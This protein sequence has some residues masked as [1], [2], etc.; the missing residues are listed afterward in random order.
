MTKHSCSI[1]NTPMTKIP[2]TLAIAALL[3]A[4]ISSIRCYAEDETAGPHEI[5]VHEKM[6]EPFLAL[7]SAEYDEA[8]ESRRNQIEYTAYLTNRTYWVH[9]HKFGHERSAVTEHALGRLNAKLLSSESFTNLFKNWK[10]HHQASDEFPGT[11]YFAKLKD[12]RKLE[13]KVATAEDWKQMH[14]ELLAFVELTAKTYKTKTT[15]QAPDDQ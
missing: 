1:Q 3:F 6:L 4:A 11:N 2:V 9:T 8:N 13:F 7:L 14:L 12:G 5:T 10:E 15:R